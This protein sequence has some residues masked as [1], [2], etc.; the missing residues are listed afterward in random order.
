[1]KN[2]DKSKL[3]IVLI[4]FIIIS[5]IVLVLNLINKNSNNK[6]EEI[7]STT[8][9]FIFDGEHY[10]L[11]NENGKQLTEFIFSDVNEFYAHTTCVENDNEQYAVLMDNG[12]YLIDF[13]E[14]ESIYQYG[15]IYVL[16][17]GKGNSKYINYKNKEFMNK[18]YSI[19][20][21]VNQEYIH[22]FYNREY[23]DTVLVVDYEGNILDTLTMVGGITNRYGTLTAGVELSDDNSYAML[24]YGE[25]YY[26]YN[27]NKHKKVMDFNS[28]CAITDISE[29]GS[30]VIL[31]VDENWII[32]EKDQK[33]LEIPKG[34]Y[35]DIKISNCGFIANTSSEF[36]FLDEKGNIIAKDI[37]SYL[38][39]KNYVIKDKNTYKF[40]TNNSLVKEL[41]LLNFESGELNNYYIGKNDRTFDYVY[42]NNKGEALNNKAYNTAHEFS[43]KGYAEVS[44]DEKEK[45]LIDKNNNKVSDNY[46]RINNIVD[47][48]DNAYFYEASK[49]SIK[50]LLSYNG[51]VLEKGF[52]NIE[53]IQNKVLVEYN[54]VTVIYDYNTQEKICNIN[55]K[56]LEFEE[57]Y[58][59]RVEN[60]EKQY[61][62]YKT[63]K[64]IYSHK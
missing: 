24:Q 13:G 55:A 45:F 32:L 17:D 25:K 44:L 33:V 61:F 57:Y 21:P 52:N 43:K 2:F 5:G 46:S 48:D 9:F 16:G 40:Y 58:A 54:D 51:K 59:Y 18:Y 41:E 27:I 38:D 10:A 47:Y 64:K 14:Y 23:E 8:S 60:G 42:Y 26:L 50:Y 36:D 34:E 29:D 49:D 63:G 30:K 3:L 1:M 28:S 4:I 12:K 62:S 39:T 53:K 31:L 15:T 35:E 37:I 6:E 19:A 7:S 56:N 11:F 20:T 22:L